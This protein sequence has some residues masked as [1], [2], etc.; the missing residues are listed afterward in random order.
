VPQDTEFFLCGPE[1]FLRELRSGL[2]ALGVDSAHVHTEAFGADTSVTAV[3]PHAP[4]GD[5]GS[6]PAVA[7][8][9]SGLTVPWDTR[10]ATLLELAEA[11]DV[12]VRWSC[13]TGVCRTCECGLVDGS[14]TYDPEPLE[15]AAPGQAL[16]CC[17]RPSRAVTLD[18]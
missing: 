15:Q 4:S 14:V 6:G 3:T 13:R 1:G 8:A 16:L 9:R 18:L 5:P 17:S 7:F 11:C 12:P 2:S 10:Y